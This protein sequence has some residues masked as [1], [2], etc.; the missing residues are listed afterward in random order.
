[1]RREAR[2]ACMRTARLRPRSA[3]TGARRLP[4]Q[5]WNRVLAGMAGLPASRSEA[6]QG[7][8][9]LAAAL[10]ARPRRRPPTRR[11]LSALLEQP[12]P[13]RE[14]ARAPGVAGR[15]LSARDTG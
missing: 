10:Q 6:E 13:D 14:P 11:R 1:M 15:M 7:A 3:P 8:E 2:T 4:R 9:T 12:S 5:V